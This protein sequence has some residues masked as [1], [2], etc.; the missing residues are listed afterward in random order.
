[1]KNLDTFTIFLIL[2]LCGV[3]FL[4]LKI[5]ELNE[6]EKIIDLNNNLNNIYIYDDCLQYSGKYYCIGDI[7]D[8]L[9]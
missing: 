3:L 7:N 2:L 8:N 9:H 1:M 4:V 5:Y 6:T